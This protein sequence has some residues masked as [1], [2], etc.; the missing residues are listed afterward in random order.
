LSPKGRGRGQETI[1]YKRPYDLFVLVV[2]HIVLFP[3]WAAL[4]VFIPV[5]IWLEDRGPIFYSQQRA[6]KDRRDFM[7]IKFRTMVPDAD[8]QGLMTG[9]DDPRVTKVGGVLRRTAL[10]ELPQVINI[11]KG[12]MSFVGPRAL[13]TEMHEEELLAEP[14]FAERLSVI[15]GLTGVAQLYLPRHCPPTRRLR[16]DL[17]YVK[18]ASL[19]LDI[20]LMLLAAWNTVTGSW[21]TGHRKVA[22]EVENSGKSMAAGK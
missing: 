17:V 14:R 18:N 19:W 3:V 16:Y 15:P 6:G 22:L 4:W 7:A 12:D 9:N 13:P 20:R 21:G 10:D 11:F 5:A 8:R 1:G 2:A